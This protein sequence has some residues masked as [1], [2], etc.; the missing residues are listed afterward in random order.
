LIGQGLATAPQ[1][2]DETV[3]GL[4]DHFEARIAAVAN[5]ENRAAGRLSV[6]VAVWTHHTPAG[7]NR[8]VSLLRG[9]QNENCCLSEAVSHVLLKDGASGIGRATAM[10]LV[11][12]KTAMS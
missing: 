4:H 1:G 12:E 10:R 2:G 6:A 3:H 5:P 9:Y 7:P 11:Q 8:V